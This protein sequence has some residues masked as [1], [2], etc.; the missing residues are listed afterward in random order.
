MPTSYFSLLLMV[1]SAAWMGNGM[2]AEPKEPTSRDS[3]QMMFPIGVVPMQQP[4][5]FFDY[6]HQLHPAVKYRL[7]DAL[8]T[9]TTAMSENPPLSPDFKAGTRPNNLN[10]LNLNPNASDEELFHRISHLLPYSLE[11]LKEMEARLG[12]DTVISMIV[13]ALLSQLVNIVL[14]PFIISILAGIF[15]G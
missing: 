8:L 12:L 4:S 7:L 11:E 10:S 2:P 5:N 1:L 9:A 6:V 14:I 13:Q 3:R 15:A